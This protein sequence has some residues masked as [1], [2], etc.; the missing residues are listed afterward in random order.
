MSKRKKAGEA[1]RKVLEQGDI[2]FFYHP[3][4]DADSVAGL[5]DVASFHLILHPL[6][7]NKYRYAAISLKGLLDNGGEGGWWARLEMVERELSQIQRKLRDTHPLPPARPCGEG[8]YAVVR[9]AGHTHLAY[10]LELPEQPGEVQ[11]ALGIPDRE[12]AFLAV[13]NPFFE[14]REEGGLSPQVMLPEYPSDMLNLFGDRRFH[15]AD[16]VSLLDYEGAEIL[17]ARRPVAA[18]EDLA[19][20][21]MPEHETEETSEVFRI[22]KLRAGEVPMSPLF[23]GHWA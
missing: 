10:A 21:L 16:P 14:A 22:L 8:V 4:S 3:K 17:I 6:D 7:E 1:E 23:E 2:F 20:E 11:K 18:G 5:E 15:A 13:L 19:G 9:H 12:N